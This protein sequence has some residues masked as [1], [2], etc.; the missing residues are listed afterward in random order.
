M[1]TLV[2][3]WGQR[4]WRNPERP[5]QAV[6][7]FVK[8][9]ATGLAPDSHQCMNVLAWIYATHPKAQLRNGPEAVRLAEEACKIQPN[10]KKLR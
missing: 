5:E 10:G 1:R 2:L 6:A 4:V 9:C 3:T 7:N 8:E